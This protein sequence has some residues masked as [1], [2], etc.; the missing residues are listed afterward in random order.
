M[1][2]LPAAD[3]EVLEPA[4]DLQV[5]AFVHGPD[6]A[7]VQP[8]VGVDGRARRVRH[9]EVTHHVLV[10][11]GTDLAL[12]AHLDGLTGRGG[13]LDL[14]VRHRLPERLGLVGVGVGGERLGEH[15]VHLGLAEQDREV[16]V[17]RGLG[18]AH[19]IR[20]HLRP[21]AHDRPQ[22]RD[23]ASGPVGVVEQ[24][25]QDRRHRQDQ[26]AALGLHQLQDE[27]RVE[28]RDD[29]VHAAPGQRP[30]AREHPAT[31]VEQRDRVDPGVAVA[32]AR[33]FGGEPGGVDDA[34]VVQ[35]RALGEAG[36]P[37][38]VDDQ[39]GV[40]GRHVGQRCRPVPARDE[41]VPVGDA[42]GLAQ[43]GQIVADALDD[44][45]HRHPAVLGAVHDPDAAG[46]AQR[47]AELL[48]AVLRIDRDDD[49]PRQR[50]SHLQQHPLGAVGLPDRDALPRPEPRQQCGGDGLGRVEHLGVGP[51]PARRGV[52]EPVDETDPF[53]HLGCDPAQQ[54]ADRRDVEI[55]VRGR[56]PVGDRG[57]CHRIRD[58]HRRRPPLAG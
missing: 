30:D 5:A 57:Q 4:R 40:V 58:R 20:G 15:P 11:A 56:R 2:V 29:D 21:A 54:G 14:D 35:Q 37:G 24:S 50:R 8:A 3:H 12:G 45:A 22:R 39:V 16:A 31:G 51:A 46:L 47:V 53:R 27:R 25:E 41:R 49:D 17:P 55:D 42:D 38:G 18:A 26:G 10:A 44:A 28:H 33:A 19:E 36:R 34:E 32:E 52:D 1:D 7:A 48:G 6:V 9:V 23:V 13:D 43:V